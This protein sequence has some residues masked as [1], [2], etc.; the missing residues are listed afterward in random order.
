MWVEFFE[1]VIFVKPGDYAHRDRAVL[2]TCTDGRSA[3]IYASG[4]H[5]VMDLIFE[6]LVGR[7]DLRRS[8]NPRAE[9][10]INNVPYVEAIGIDIDVEGDITT[11]RMEA[12][13]VSEYIE[14]I[15]G[16]PFVVFTGGKGYAVII[17]ITPLAPDDRTYRELVKS[18]VSA[19]KILHA[20]LNPGI[21]YHV[22]VP[23]TRHTKTG[24]LVV[25]YDYKRDV[26][27]DDIKKIEELFDGASPVNIELSPEQRIAVYKRSAVSRSKRIEWIEKAE[28][29]CIPDCRKR[30][31]LAVLARYLVNVLRLDTEKA[32]M[33]IKEFSERCN[34][35]MY[36]SW[37]RHV[38]NR[39]KEKKLMPYKCHEFF[40]GEKKFSCKEVSYSC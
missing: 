4:L 6:S 5:D 20:D 34:S 11:A 8:V 18:I 12:K 26:H 1:K 38:V 29:N 27:V 25:A 17:P 40:G 7:C 37:I 21:K 22:R 3:Q 32:V 28:Y 16:K 15:G 39:V 35:K 31:V 10:D 9:G 14:R 24:N 19:T 2:Y 36:E 30:F 33:R 13:A 23:M